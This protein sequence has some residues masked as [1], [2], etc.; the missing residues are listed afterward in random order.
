M[1]PICIISLCPITDVR[2]AR[3]GRLEWLMDTI[4]ERVISVKIHPMVRPGSL[5][6]YELIVLWL[7][8]L[9]SHVLGRSL[10]VVAGDIV[11]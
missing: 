9:F 7:D 1:S 4:R 2:I 8:M 6:C 11:F 10:V 5:S 3:S